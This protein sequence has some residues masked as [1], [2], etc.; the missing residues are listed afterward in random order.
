MGLCQQAPIL[1]KNSLSTKNK[2]GFINGTLARP[3]DSDV[4]RY[5][6]WTRANDKPISWIL[7]SVSKDIPASVLFLDTAVEIWADF[8][9]RFKQSNGPRIFRI[10]RDLMNLSQEQSR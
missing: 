9:D 5:N 6:A 8:R 10:R 4:E 2:L 3:V 7:N 1:T